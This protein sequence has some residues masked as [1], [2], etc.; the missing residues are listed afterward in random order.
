MN[1]NLTTTAVAD[2]PEWLDSTE[3]IRF[4][5]GGVTVNSAAAGIP[6]AN[7]AGRKI[8]PSGTPLIKVGTKWEPEYGATDLPTCILW[9]TLDVTAGDAHGGAIDHGRVRLAALPV[10]IHADAQAS[11]RGVGITFRA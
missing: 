3:G 8:V 7:A 6:A 1:L 10:T 5:T 11:L 9:E 2:S 4:L